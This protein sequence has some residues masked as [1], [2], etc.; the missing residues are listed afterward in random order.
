[1]L[2]LFS[3]KFEFVWFYKKVILKYQLSSF[4][5]TLLM[6]IITKVR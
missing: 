3:A 2:K 5:K 6:N 4:S 1:M